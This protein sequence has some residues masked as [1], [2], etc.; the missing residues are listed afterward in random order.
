MG[1]SY[2]PRASRPAQKLYQSPA[3]HH[4]Q[5]NEAQLDEQEEMRELDGD[6][7]D[8]NM[9]DDANT[10]SVG[11]DTVSD[12]SNIEYYPGASTTYGTGATFMTEFFSDK[13]ADLR[14]ENLFYPFA[15]QEDWQ[16]GSWLLRSGLSM[17]AI[18]SFLSLDLVSIL[19]Q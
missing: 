4:D 3:Q 18:D 17:A 2:Q 10:D 8:T 1:I 16:L 6:W 5:F 11:P 9:L 14:R 15:S 19:Y 13:Y 7:E 12:A